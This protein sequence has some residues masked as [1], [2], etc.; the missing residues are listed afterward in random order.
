MS[1]AKVP[2]IRVPVEFAF[3]GR[4]V[5]AD[6][7]LSEYGPG[8]EGPERISDLLLGGD[9]LLPAMVEDHVLLVGCASLLFVRVDESEV[10]TGGVPRE[11]T[12]EIPVDVTLDDG[13]RHVGAFRAAGP[14]GRSR[15]QDYLN[16]SPR[17]V[18]LFAASR[19]TWLNRRRIQTILLG[20]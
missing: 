6:V 11:G 9:D 14:P 12:V 20:G 2:K 19:V 1:D 18:P 7:F 10:G 16:G 4:V 15:L 8:H 5:R 13:S 3:S 17:F